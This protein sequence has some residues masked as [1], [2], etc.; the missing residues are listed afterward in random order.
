MASRNRHFPSPENSFRKKI[1]YASKFQEKCKTEFYFIESSDRGDS[2]T[3]CML[4]KSNF[5][6]AAMTHKWNRSQ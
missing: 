6:V 1:Q 2:F 4:C 3:F 5:S